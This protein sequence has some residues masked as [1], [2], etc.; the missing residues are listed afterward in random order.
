[1]PTGAADRQAAALSRPADLASR[2]Q[3]GSSRD[4][5]TGRQTVLNRIAYHRSAVTA[6]PSASPR[7]PCP[8]PR[9]TAHLPSLAGLG[10]T[11][12]VCRAGGVKTLVSET[13]RLSTA[14]IATPA[15]RLSRQVRP[16]PWRPTRRNAVAVVDHRA[17]KQ[18]YGYTVNDGYLADTVNQIGLGAFLAMEPIGTTGGDAHQPAGDTVADGIS[19]TVPFPVPRALSQPAHTRRRWGLPPFLRLRGDPTGVGRGG[20]SLGRAS[21]GG[22]IVAGR[23]RVGRSR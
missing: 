8:D 23:A 20:P 17:N 11:A 15:A 22:S 13:D 3:R 12:R 4:A 1:M 19:Q 7:P 5:P 14:D 2:P 18:S 10:V 16:L 6:Q 9:H 21:T